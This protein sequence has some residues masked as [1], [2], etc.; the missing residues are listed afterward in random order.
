MAQRSQ[1]TSMAT[2]TV[3]ADEWVLKVNWPLY[4]VLMSA[5]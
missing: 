1:Y 5:C 3:R 4:R 2:K